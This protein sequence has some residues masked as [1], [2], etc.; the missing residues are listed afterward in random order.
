MQ[1]ILII[2]F[3]A[4]GDLCLLAWSMSRYARDKSVTDRHI[5]L[6]TKEAFVPLMEK[7]QG[8]DR[9]I[10]L[11]NPGNF[12]Q[13]REL[14]KILQQENFDTIFDAHNILRSHLLLFLMKRRPF[15]RLKKH[16][17]AR[18]TLLQSG[19]SHS[20]LQLTMVD[21]FDALF[22]PGMSDTSVPHQY[23]L[24]TSPNNG[25]TPL[26]LA[27]GA[28]WNSKRWPEENYASLLSQFCSRNKAPVRIFLGPREELWFQE[29]QLRKV[30]ESFPQ[31]EIIRNQSLVQVAD[32]LAQ[33]ST[34]VTND[35]GLLHLAEAG[36]T[37]VL[38]FF[39]PTVKQFGYF[40]RLD[41]S[42]VLELELQCRPCSRNGKKDCHRGDLACLKPI[43]SQLALTTLLQ[44]PFMTEPC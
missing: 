8:L 7:T 19:K 6:V 35:S 13:L 23:P 25:P 3:G 42:R 34:V 30:A 29:S 17:R 37:S 1:K 15:Q 20:N 12:Q 43:E 5:T 32:Q 14:A 26:G 22:T 28:Q 18:L 40:P 2:R 38:A 11:P 4:L 41:D 10:G 9:V 39:G 36:G 16:T 27:P 24:E 31:V 44:M 33:C 21:R